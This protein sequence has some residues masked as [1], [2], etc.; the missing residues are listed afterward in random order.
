M[1]FGE[2]QKPKLF[3]ESLI[4]ERSAGNPHATFCEGEGLPVSGSLLYSI[5]VVYFTLEDHL[6]TNHF[7]SNFSIF[8]LTMNPKDG[9]VI[10]FLI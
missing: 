1:L 5:N 4:E 10:Q 8:P 9:I 2:M 3:C 7:Q 6:T